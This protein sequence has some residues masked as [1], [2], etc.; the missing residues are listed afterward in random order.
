MFITGSPG[1]KY[2]M[3]NTTKIT[4]SMTGII[5][6]MRFNVYLSN[7][8]FLPYYVRQATFVQMAMAHVDDKQML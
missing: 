1:L 4:P 2:I 3:V 5:H 6:N 8:R 7:V